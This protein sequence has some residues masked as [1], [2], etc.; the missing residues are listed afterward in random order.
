MLWQKGVTL[1]P[2]Q[3]LVL[4]C[5]QYEPFEN[6]VG[7]GEITPYEQLLLFPQ[8]FLKDLY[9]RCIKTRACFGKRLKFRKMQG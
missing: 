9:C 6:T 8:C 4:M 5:L 1:F 2:T 3:A 7:K